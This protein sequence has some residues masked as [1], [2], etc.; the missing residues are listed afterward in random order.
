MYKVSIEKQCGCFKRS[1]MP[2][3]KSFETKDE[4]L[5]EAQAWAKDM[6]ESFCKKHAFDVI[7]DGEHLMI[8]LAS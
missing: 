3:V 7:E 6:N 8:R 5:V 4:A 2:A 1:N